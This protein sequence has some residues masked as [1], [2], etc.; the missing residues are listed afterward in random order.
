VTKERLS[1]MRSLRISQLLHP[2]ETVLDDSIGCA[3]W[4][5]ASGEGILYSN[6]GVIYN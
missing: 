3:M 1:E 4:H 2:L 5:A 6:D